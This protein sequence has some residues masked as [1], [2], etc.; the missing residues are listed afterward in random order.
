MLKPSN[1]P[2]FL[3]LVRL[4]TSEDGINF[5]DIREGV[6]F[7]GSVRTFRFQ[8]VAARFVRANIRS[9]L[10]TEIGLRELGIFPK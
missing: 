10:G 3:Q 1:L 7:P 2:S 5:T 9:L 8:P 4:Q 6:E